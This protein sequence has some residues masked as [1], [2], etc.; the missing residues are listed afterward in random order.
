M[1]DHNIQDDN[2]LSNIINYIIQF[3]ITYKLMLLVIVI[4]SIGYSFYIK[5]TYKPT[6]FSSAIIETHEIIERDIMKEIVNDFFKNLQKQASLKKY[7]TTKKNY[8]SHKLRSDTIK[9]SSRF[10]LD[11]IISSDKNTKDIDVELTSHIINHE[12]IIKAKEN[13]LK[14]LNQLWSVLNKHLNKDTNIIKEI[15]LIEKE[16]N[17]TNQLKNIENYSPMDKGFGVPVLKENSRLLLIKNFCKAFISGILL[18]GF[19]IYLK[20]KLART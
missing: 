1:N 2:N 18:F 17:L 20:K 14:E 6:Y 10:Y 7:E 4:I 9:N 19:Y 15:S 13:K 12:M 16:I 8:I 5:N 3:V 11:I